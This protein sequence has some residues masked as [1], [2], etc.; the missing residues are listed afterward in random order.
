MIHI[1][2]FGWA[3]EY[4]F[5]MLEIASAFIFFYYW[6]RLDPRTHQ[7]VGWI[8]AFSAWISL[9]LITGITAFMLNPGAWP[10]APRLL[11]GLLQP[12]IP[13]AGAGAHRRVAP[14][15]IALRLPARGAH[16]EADLAL[17]G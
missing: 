13:A 7:T 4:V 6:E 16:G 17:R 10:R 14:A 5:F 3:M 1:F 12:A 2:V 11:G 9:V 8:Y 15:G